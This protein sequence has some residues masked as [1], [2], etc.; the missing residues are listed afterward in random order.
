MIFKKNHAKIVSSLYFDKIQ[1][2]M[3][4][5]EIN[6]GFGKGNYGCYTKLVDTN[7][8]LISIRLLLTWTEVLHGGLYGIQVWRQGEV[9]REVLSSFYNIRF[10]RRPVSSSMTV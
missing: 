8:D 5:K 6:F 1:D 4:I 9:Y 10:T 7:Q 2:G 3:C